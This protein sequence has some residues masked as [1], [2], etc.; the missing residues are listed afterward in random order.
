MTTNYFALIF[1]SRPQAV[2][3]Y[4]RLVSKGLDPKAVTPFRPGDGDLDG[5]A[6]SFPVPA[7]M[8]VI[9]QECFIAKVHKTYIKSCCAVVEYHSVQQ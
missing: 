8:P 5:K 9:N 3:C 7:N 4:R 1:A 6:F 2:H